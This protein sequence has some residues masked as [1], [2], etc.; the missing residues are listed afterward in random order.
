MS[1]RIVPIATLLIVV[2]ALLAA[3]P[4]ESVPLPIA[5]V[6]ASAFQDP[7]VP[8]NTLDGDLGTRWSAQGDGQ[9]IRYE[10]TA[11]DTVSQVSVAWYQGD[12]RTASFNVETSEDGVTWISAH[13]GSSSGETLD[14]QPVDI[15]DTFACFVRIVGFGNSQNNWNSIT[16]VQIEGFDALPLETIPVSLPALEELCAP[17]LAQP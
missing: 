8:E 14:P 7:N 12:V 5:G 17:L 15:D 13:S 6:T 11:C 4:A 2:G 16:E 1:P 3:P 10:L 9:W